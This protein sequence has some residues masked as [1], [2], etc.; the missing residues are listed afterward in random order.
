MPLLPYVYFN[1]FSY[2]FPSPSSLPFQTSFPAFSWNTCIY[3]QSCLH[4]IVFILHK[5]WGHRFEFTR[6]SRPVLC[7]TLNCLA[8]W[9]IIFSTPFL[10]WF[11][12]HLNCFLLP[13]FQSSFLTAFHSFGDQAPNWDW[14]NPNPLC[15]APVSQCKSFCSFFPS[16]MH[17]CIHSVFLSI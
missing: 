3:S 1:F 16:L 14:P 12:P 8:Y 7:H 17:S 13:V 6:M 11:F 10:C 15:N 2:M 9:F 4:S 5:L